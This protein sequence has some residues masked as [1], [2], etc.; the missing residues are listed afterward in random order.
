MRRMDSVASRRDVGG[1][2]TASTSQDRVTI[3]GGTTTLTASATRCGC[4]AMLLAA[5]ASGLRDGGAQFVS[6]QHAG[7]DANAAALGP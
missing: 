2:S 1:D 4:A 7:C 5:V 3:G 6:L